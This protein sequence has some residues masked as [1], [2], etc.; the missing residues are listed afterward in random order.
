MPG[1]RLEEIRARVTKPLAVGFGISQHAHYELL[2]D[3]C[4][5][6]V[7]GSAIVRAVASGEAADG[8]ERAA[9]VVRTIL[10]KAAGLPI[11]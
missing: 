10:D 8:P 6:I 7:V 4:D 11:P 2:R 3:R 5:A 9:A 1:A